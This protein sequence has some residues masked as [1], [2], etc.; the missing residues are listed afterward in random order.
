MQ[1]IRVALVSFWLQY[2]KMYWHNGW[3]KGGGESEGG[4]FEEGEGLVV[5]FTLF[6]TRSSL[7]T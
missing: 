7:K 4:R 6:K 2:V 1:L 3:V 5:I